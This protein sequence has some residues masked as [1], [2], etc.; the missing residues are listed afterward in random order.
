MDI[1]SRSAWGARSPKAPYVAIAGSEGILAHHLGD[2]V[3]RDPNRTNYAELM[4][5]TQNFHMD[6][7]GWNDFAYGFAVGG[8][9]AYM[10]RGWGVIDG[11]DT[12]RG[13]LMHSVLWL[14]DSFVNEIPD[15]DMAVIWAL[16]DEH[17]RIYG[18]KFE[19]G[20]RDVNSTGCPG[21]HIY[22][23]LQTGR[24]VS[25]PVIQQPLNFYKDTSMYTVTNADG[26]VITYRIKNNIL[27]ASWRN[28][29][30]T[31]SKWAPVVEGK[32]LNLG[33][34]TTAGTQI[35][36]PTVMETAF[37]DINTT[38]VQ[39]KPNEIFKVWITDEL[40]K[41]LSSL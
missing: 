9:R 1:I 4:R 38:L 37:G 35:W 11:A 23:K 25:V 12:D 6:G 29:D 34:P 24:P 8:G 30:G 19:G 17:N 7:R 36:I 33:Q 31:R 22:A 16:F 15:T 20:H 41:V 26:L 27:E 10:G 28:L 18:K 13:R 39:S 40:H 5:Q 21:D 14:G 32:T 2:N 3:V